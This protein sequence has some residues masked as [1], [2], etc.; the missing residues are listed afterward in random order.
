VGQQRG[1]VGGASGTGGTTRG[2]WRALGGGQ[3]A[4]PVAGGMGEGSQSEVEE[5]QEGKKEEYLWTLHNDA[6]CSLF[7]KYLLHVIHVQT[8][9]AF[10]GRI[11]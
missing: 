4:P 9:N 8:T 2:M 3:R 10:E 5:G 7:L 1:D 11:F 6:F